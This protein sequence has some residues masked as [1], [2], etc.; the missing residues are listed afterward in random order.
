MVE[1]KMMVKENLKF[2][3]M[4]VSKADFTKQ[5]HKVTFWGYVWYTIS[6]LL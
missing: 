4:D 3:N 1:F 5:L 6:F 2:I